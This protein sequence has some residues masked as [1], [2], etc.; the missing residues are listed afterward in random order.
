VIEARNLSKSYGDRRALD[1]V[2][3][4]ASPGSVLGLL[5]PNGAGKSTA[6]RILAGYLVPS[7][8]TAVVAGHDVQEA[9]REVRRRLGYLP[10]SASLYLEMRVREYL[11]YR[12]ALKEVPR[13]ERPRRVDAALGTCGLGD[14]RDRILGQLSKGF[15]Q[16]V[17]LAAALVH[18]PEVLVLDEPTV[19]LDPLQMREIRALVKRLGRERTVLFSTHILPEA[20]AVCDRV[21]IL[22]RGQVLADA[23]PRELAAALHPRELRVEVVGEARLAAGALRRLPGLEVE[24]SQ[25]QPTVRLAVRSATAVDT[26][27]R[28]RISTALTESGVVVVELSAPGATLDDVFARLTRREEA[29]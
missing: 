25:E 12:A 8:G 21:V 15:R 1:G 23:P 7:A 19:G 11:G 16:R 27:L 9:S 14:V 17:S 3:F 10:E 5:G 18:D 6:M 2:S 22:D 24:I 29:P 13:R 28:A 20:E 26:Q 4:S